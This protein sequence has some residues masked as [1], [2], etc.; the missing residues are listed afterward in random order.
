[1]RLT[2]TLDM[3]G[4]QL[5]SSWSKTRRKNGETLQKKISTLLGSWRSGKFMPL[6]LRPWSA[7]TF[8]LS[9]V[10]FRC[11]TV[12][13]RE[14]D[15]SAINSSLKKWLYADLLLKPEEIVL[16]RSMWSGGLGLVSV[17][18][19]SIAY[20]IKT[21]L[22]LA[23]N[24]HY[25][26]SPYLS[27]LFRVHVLHEDLNCPPPPPYYSN[28]FFDYILQAKTTGRDIVKMS[29]RQ[30]YHYLLNKDLLK[31]EIDDGSEIYRPCRVERLSPDYDWITTWKR[32]RLSAMS[33]STMTFLWKLLH[34]LL[35][36]EERLF[37]TLGNVSSSCRSGCPENTV[38]SLEHCLFSCSLICEIGMWL[39]NTVQ[40]C[41]PLVN[42]ENVLKLD[43][44]ANNTI[45]WVVAYTLE[46]IWRNRSSR[47]KVGLTSCLGYL[48]FEAM[49]LEETP[50]SQLAARI[51]EILGRT[52][53]AFGE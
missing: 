46:F 20:L 33:S 32:I 37:Q 8:A 10:W 5:C 22:E 23:V 3:V 43:F 34:H 49:K 38:A 17:K 36:T 51:L 41:F 21:F 53:S 2:D 27:Q 12:N 13:L 48:K 39:L 44:P 11:A 31:A 26:S 30:W 47:K 29:T 7:N 14:A 18:H 6:T 40:S 19:K 1:M 4:V 50:Y 16:F 35:P 45:E 24:P 9:K 28:Q 15:F 42:A 25:I 52:Q